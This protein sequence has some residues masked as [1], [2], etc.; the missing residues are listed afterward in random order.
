MRHLR[1]SMTAA[2]ATLAMTAT[3]LLAGN[4]TPDVIFGSGNA[5]G[6]FT[7]DQGSGVEL[8]LRGKLRFNES[9]SPENTFNYDGV[10]TYTFRRGNPPTGFGF[11]P[12]N[13]TT[14][15]WNFEWSINSDYNDT[16]GDKLDDFKYELSLDADSS[17]G[18]NF[19]SF[20]PI[21]DQNPGANN[22]VQWDHGIGNNSTGNGG[23]T[24]ILNDSDSDD[25]GYGNLIADNNVAQN[26]W[27][28]EFFND[29]GKLT[30]FDPNDVGTYTITL[31]AFNANDEK[32]AGSSININVVPSPSAAFGG[33]MLLGGLALRRRR[34][35]V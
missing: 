1:T 16:S 35:V 4:V 21:N 10:N 11:D 28:Y 17:A 31:S 29:S 5:N 25:D 26:S 14:P 22:Q 24:K 9:N 19:E 8:G 27:S 23:G 20:D 7:I 3:P 6:S 33:L 2:T 18:T 13:P 32:V 12:N 34:R 15:V 30:S